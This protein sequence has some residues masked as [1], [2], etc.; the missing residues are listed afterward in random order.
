MSDT[1]K[2]KARRRRKVAAQGKD[3]KKKLEKLGT[4]PKFPLDPDKASG[5]KA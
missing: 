2:T 4:T 1:G 5:A 3:R